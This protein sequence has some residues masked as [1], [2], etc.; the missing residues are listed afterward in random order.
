MEKLTLEHIKEGQVLL[1]DKPLH[2]TSF[3][4]VNKVRWLIKQ[5]F[6]LKKIKVGHAGTL[7]PLASGLV[8]LCTG[9]ATKT[10]ET[11]MGQTKVYT[12]EFTLGATTPSY[13]METEVDETFD[14]SHITDKLIDQV[15]P[16]FQGEIM[17]RPPIFSALKKEGKRLYEFARKGE[18]VDIPKRQVKIDNFKI[19][20]NNLPKLK[21]KVQCSKGTYIRSLAYDF[22]KALDSGAYLSELRRTQIGDYRVEDALSVEDFQNLLND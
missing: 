19:L 13:D 14:S 4:V 3:Q 5:K 18:E 1:F 20:E 6:D 11:L 17:Q 9:K 10:I 8:I 16:Q 7:D 15:L 12:G 22:G 21:F 2:W